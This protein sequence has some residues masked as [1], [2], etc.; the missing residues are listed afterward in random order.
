MNGD[1]LLLTEQ[2]KKRFT[3]WLLLQ[4]SSNIGLVEQ[5]DKVGMAGSPL[6]KTMKV[7]ADACEIIALDIMKSE[8]ISI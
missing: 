3:E 2:E 4:A 7:K 6:A 8:S 5:M 1:G